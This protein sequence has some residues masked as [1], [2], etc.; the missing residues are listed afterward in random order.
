M[1]TMTTIVTHNQLIDFTVVR[2]IRFSRDYDCGKLKINIK[3]L[4]FYNAICI[5]K[6][7]NVHIYFEL[8]EMTKENDHIITKL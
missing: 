2:I 7:H 4:V 6:N 3:S 5:V 8:G 1:P